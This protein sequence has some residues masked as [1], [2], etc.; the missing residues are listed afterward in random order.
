[1]AGL[2]APPTIPKSIRSLVWVSTHSGNANSVNVDPVNE[3]IC[4]DAMMANFP[5]PGSVSADS[6]PLGS[7]DPSLGWWPGLTVSLATLLSCSH[8]VAAPPRAGRVRP[9]SVCSATR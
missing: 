5:S 1:M 9:D 3:I 8:H 2:P 7:T 4:P 6:R